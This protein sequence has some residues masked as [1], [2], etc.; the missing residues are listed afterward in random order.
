MELL[1]HNP[2]KEAI[3]TTQLGIVG[4]VDGTTNVFDAHEVAH[5]VKDELLAS[6]LNIKDVLIHVEPYLD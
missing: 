6:D 4:R 1:E 3:R 5:Q 2:S